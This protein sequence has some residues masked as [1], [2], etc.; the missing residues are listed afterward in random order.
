MKNSLYRIFWGLFFLACAGYAIAS[1]MGVLSY[2]LTFWSVLGTVIFAL[3]LIDGLLNLR[4]GES[5][6][7]VAFL[8]MVYAGP[9]HITKLVPWTILLAALLVTIGLGIIFR[10]RFHT[11]VFANK[12]MRQLRHKRENLFDNLFTETTTNENDRHVVI[13][14]NLSDSARYIKSQELE[15]IDVRARM[16]EINLYLDNAKAAGDQVEMNLDLSMSS[17]T[18]YLPLSWQVQSNISSNSIFGDLE[19]DGSSNGGGPT[20]ILNGNSSMSN[21]R[22]EYV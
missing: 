5:V 2:H 15:T 11:V 12:K 1:Q 17:L 16:S 18:I 9:L 14:Q 7:S 20:L 19:I 6:F 22:V 8:L 3:S 10:N 13:N 4:I 21:I